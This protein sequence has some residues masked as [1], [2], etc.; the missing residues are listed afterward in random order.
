MTINT[1][2]L[3]TVVQNVSGAAGQF[4]FIPPHGRWLESNELVAVPGDLFTQLAPNKRKSASFRQALKDNV[5]QI[6]RTPAVH[7]F[8]A[9]TD[10]VKTLSLN[11]GELG[12]ADPC[13]S[14]DEVFSSDGDYTP[15]T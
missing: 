3:D 13:W 9:G 2:C 11:G 12:I 4:N 14:E 8:D 7:I 15:A 1:E 10:T 5:I 6:I